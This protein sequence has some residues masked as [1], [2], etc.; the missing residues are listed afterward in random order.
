M[1]QKLIDDVRE[2]TGSALRQT[3][4][5]LAAAVFL[6]VTVSFLCAAAFVFVLERYGLIQACLA[7]AGVFFIATLLAAMSY[8]VQKRQQVNKPKPPSPSAMQAALSDPMVLA[9]G[10]QI[11]RTIGIKRIIPLLAIAGAAL[12][13]M[14]NRNAAAKEEPGE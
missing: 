1:L 7:G 9:A 12:G 13:F 5:A 11:V 6:F 14:A 10:L 2:S 4:L 8:A 3:S